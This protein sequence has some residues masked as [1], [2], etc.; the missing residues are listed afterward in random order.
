MLTVFTDKSNKEY[1]TANDILLIVDDSNELLEFISEALCDKF[2][3]ILTAS[4]GKEALKI[5]EKNI[6]NIIVSDVMMPEMDGYELCNKIKNNPNLNHI[7]VVLL[8]ARDEDKSSELGY[9]AGAD[10]YITKPFEIESLLKVIKGL[11]NNREQTKQHYMNLSVIPDIDK[12]DISNTNEIFLQKLNSVIKENISNPELDIN[13]ICSAIGMSR[14]SFYN[15]LKSVTDISAND[16]INKVR[17]E[18]GKSLIISTDMSFTEISFKSGFTSSNYFSRLFK[19]YTNMTP[20]QFKKLY[21][22]IN[23]H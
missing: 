23:K 5:I 3:S 6:P 22:D 16:Y 14:A 4:N 2:K 10:T 13:F 8:T 11:L 18:Y 12:M 1:S 19:Q 9:E 20:T 17:L 21:S 15:K 7:P